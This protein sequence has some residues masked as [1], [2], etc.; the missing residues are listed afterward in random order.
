MSN[1]VKVDEAYSNWITEI[2][3]RFRQCQIR[4][5]VKTNDEMLRFYWT[6]GSDMEER[7]ASYEWGSH[8]Y[9]QISKDLLKELPEVGS[10]SPRNL[11]YM[12]QF[13]RLFPDALNAKQVVSQ[14]EFGEIV[15][16]D[17][18]QFDDRELVFM[19]PWGHMVQIINKCKGD[20]NKA[21]F[22]VK[23]TLENNWSRAVLLNFLDT[24]LYE[25]QGK[26]I[27]NFSLTLPE[28]Q[29][30]L[31]Q[32]MTKDPYCFDF[33]T[34]QQ[35]YNEKELKDALMSKAEKFLM[36]LGTGFALMGREVR[37]EVGDTEKYLDMLFYNTRRHCYVV[38]EVKAVDFDS[39]FAGQLGT[40]V[41]A[42]NHQIKTELDNPTIGL[43]ICKGMDKVEA[44]YALESTSQP[45]GI[46]SY[47][48]SKLVP[49]EFKGS[50]PTIEEIEA[51]L[52]DES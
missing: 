5:A 33:L 14:L 23:K 27:T 48:L 21:L 22:Y 51:E 45:L 31:A 29:S 40:Y 46:S 42:V 20:K 49:D 7:K 43:L 38:V 32:Q 52:S 24:D 37:L 1:I 12:H 47:E 39:S 11:L 44:Q 34:L 25:R 19:V 15:K 17:V 30:D 2:S 13:Y 8:F 16:Q 10:F 35:R 50:M 9:S 26:A 36:E 41:V 4:A 6:L 3:K 18:S 28:N